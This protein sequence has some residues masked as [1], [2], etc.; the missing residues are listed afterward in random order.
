VTESVRRPIV[1]LELLA[2]FIVVVG[3]AGLAVRGGW[4]TEVD[5]FLY[6]RVVTL[7]AG[8]VPEDIVILGIDEQSLN[9]IGRW[10]WARGEQA[11][12]WTALAAAQP[13]GVLIDLIYSEPTT[14]EQDNLLATSLHKLPQLTLPILIDAVTDSGQLIEVLPLPQFIEAAE[15]LG[16]V[17]TVLDDD[18]I[19]RGL[20]LYQGISTP[21]WPHVALS[22]AFAGDP[23]EASCEPTDF[24]IVNVPCDYRLVPF[25]GEPGTFAHISARD[26]LLS[27]ENS[28]QDLAATAAMLRSKTVLVGVTAT[29]VSDWVTTPVS[30]GLR[31]MAGVEFNAN[32]LTAIQQKTLISVAGYWPILILTLLL[33]ALPP[34]VLPRLPPG[35]MLLATIGF[36]LLSVLLFYALL[37]FARVY[38]PLSAAGLAAALTY[39][40]WSWRRLEVA[41]RFFSGEIERFSAER[42]QLGTREVNDVQFQS[43]APY[44]GELLVA[45]AQLVPTTFDPDALIAAQQ[46]PH[47]EDTHK[48]RGVTARGG[49]AFELSLVRDSKFT[50]AEQDF[51][52]RM[53]QGMSS[54]DRVPS[55]PIEQL[56]TQIRQLNRL[57]D[58]VRTTRDVHMKSFEQVT[59]GVCVIA[60]NGLV[61]YANTSFTRLTKV[62]VDQNILQ[63]SRHVTAPEGDTWPQIVY[64]VVV[65]AES[66]S[67]EA[68]AQSSH[69]VL[70]CAPLRIA[71][72]AKGYWLMTVVDVSDIRLAQRQREEAL[73]FLS[74]DLRSPM[75]SILALLRRSHT[76]DSAL[77]RQIEGYAQRSLHVSEQFVQLSRVENQEV[78]NIYE[79]EL[80]A[81]AS[82]AMEQVYEQA[83]AKGISIELNDESG[84]DGLWLMA[85]GELLERAVLNL[86]TNAIKYSREDTSIWVRV[87]YA[88]TGEPAVSVKDQGFGI[89]AGELDRVFDPYFRSR[90]REIAQQRGV[91]LGLRFVKTVTERHGGRVQ[92]VSQPDKGSTFTLYFAQSSVVDLGG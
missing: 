31:P 85:S 17:H 68:K 4:L 15:N 42:L 1:L 69:I 81:V 38:L 91:G 86:L 77:L 11:Q 57:A 22:Y 6:D 72:D 59:S 26:L 20:H 43:M 90:V 21:H 5:R 45:R 18:G 60:T 82:N 7:I 50:P 8:D 23:P 63:I 88:D 36:V 55:M 39:P 73:A 70:D 75:V 71:D 87:F 64:R 41:W 47:D 29:G 2:L 37:Y 27:G 89:P 19:S 44:L 80:G 24:S 14:I 16:H 67:F 58:D 40:L 56:N 52:T 12:L 33:A 66:V 49:R 53:L 32:V 92:V 13:A 83:A 79:V 51:V 46:R 35:S 74:H 9:Q 48:L 34:L 54:V 65:E 30:G 10:P 3:F 84:E 62:G 28:T 78:L 76:D 25:V 61:E